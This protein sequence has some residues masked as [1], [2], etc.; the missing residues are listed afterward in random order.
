V[1][2]LAA[3]VEAGGKGCDGT[4]QGGGRG[5]DMEGGGGVN[6]KSVVRDWSRGTLFP[7]G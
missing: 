3:G 7:A 5:G 2:R 4:R 6:G 1:V